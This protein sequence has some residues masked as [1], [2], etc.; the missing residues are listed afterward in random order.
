MR[1]G[2]FD[3]LI[4]ELQVVELPPQRSLK[5]DRGSSSYHALSYCRGHET[6]R[7][8]ET[9]KCG[10]KALGV[11]KTL[12]NILQY[13][14]AGGHRTLWVDAICINQGDREER[15]AQVLL[16]SR[17]YEC[18]ESILIWLGEANAT[19]DGEPQPSITLFQEAGA[20]T[21]KERFGSFFRYLRHPWWRRIWSIQEIVL[22][23][24]VDII[25]QHEE[26]AWDTFWG[27]ATIDASPHLLH[28]ASNLP[29]SVLPAIRFYRLVST[30]KS[31]PILRKKDISSRA[32]LDA[33]LA[34]EAATEWT[35]IHNFAATLSTTQ[36]QD[37]VYAF[38]GLAQL[39]GIELTSLN[40]S[41]SAANI[42]LEAGVAVLKRWRNCR[43]RIEKLGE[44]LVE[45]QPCIVA[46]GTPSGR[47]VSP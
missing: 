36:P 43:V 19:P 37:R 8:S 18:A 15:Q 5:T 3:E 25:L 6:E 13:L 12:L 14:S 40:L 46:C 41:S 11:N 23:H 24:R 26:V 31:I 30:I 21:E 35:R 28:Y 27:R 16:M 4:L 2:E 47:N 33:G 34:K 1:E 42:F 38:L 29:Y 22:S 9:I 44:V 45:V 39:F 32:Y 17:I 7:I 20:L 10:G